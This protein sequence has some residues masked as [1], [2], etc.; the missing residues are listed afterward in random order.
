MNPRPIP[1]PNQKIRDPG[2]GEM[3]LY[4]LGALVF[5]IILWGILAK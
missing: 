4:L 5:V 2:G 1:P 3:V